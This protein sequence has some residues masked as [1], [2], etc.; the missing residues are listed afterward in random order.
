MDTPE[1][2]VYLAL[3]GSGGSRIFGSVA[4]VILHLD[5]GY[6]VANAVEQARVHDQLSPAY[7]S[8]SRL[9]TRLEREL[10]R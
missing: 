1:G 8:W 2:D 5:W 3:G 4:Q 10:T 7:V 6:D 9:R